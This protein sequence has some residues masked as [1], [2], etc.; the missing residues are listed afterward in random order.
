MRIMMINETLS[1]HDDICNKIALFAKPAL[2]RT[3]LIVDSAKSI[4][5]N[6]REWSY[7]LCHE[8]DIWQ[9]L[10]QHILNHYFLSHYYFSIKKIEYT[11]Q[12]TC[13]R[14]I[15]SQDSWDKIRPTFIEQNRFK[16]YVDQILAIQRIDNALARFYKHRNAQKQYEKLFSTFM[17]DNGVV[18]GNNPGE[19]QYELLHQEE[20]SMCTEW[21][22]DP[23]DFPFED[24]DYKTDKKSDAEREKYI[25]DLVRKCY[26]NPGIQFESHNQIDLH[27]QLDLHI[28]PQE[29][30]ERAARLWELSPMEEAEILLK[31]F[32]KN[33][34][35]SQHQNEA[36]DKSYLK[37]KAI[38]MITGRAVLLL[39]MDSYTRIRMKYY[40]DQES[41]VE[42]REKTKDDEIEWW[43]F[44]QFCDEYRGGIE[45]IIELSEFRVDGQLITVNALK[46][47]LKS[48]NKRIG[49]KLK[50]YEPVTIVCDILDEYHKYAESITNYVVKY[51]TPPMEQDIDDNETRPRKINVPV[52][53]DVMVIPQ[54]TKSVK[55]TQYN[56]DDDDD[57][58]DSDYDEKSEISNNQSSK[59]HVTTNDKGYN[60][61]DTDHEWMGLGGKDNLKSN[62]H[63][64]QEI[65]NIGRY[66]QECGYQENTDFFVEL[67]KPDDLIPRKIEETFAK[68]HEKCFGARNESHQRFV[69]I[70]DRRDPKSLKDNAGK[71]ANYALNNKDWSDQVYCIQM[72]QEHGGV[73]PTE[74]VRLPEALFDLSHCILPP[75][76]TNIKDRIAKPIGINDSLNGYMFV[77][78]YHVYN[79]DTIRSYFSYCGSTQRFE[80]VDVEKFWPSLF[81]QQPTKIPHKFDKTDK[82]N[83]NAMRDAE[84]DTFMYTLNDSKD[85]KDP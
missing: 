44:E 35:K 8:D 52:Q 77:L 20:E 29:T 38:D 3:I 23:Q 82:E 73:M 51:A 70:V 49:G 25:L 68:L 83:V 63:N 53:I 28:P 61:T 16:I 6:H 4:K 66:L 80:L 79:P 60:I 81:I 12:D 2:M 55:S 46:D 13:I 34:F 41:K 17:K 67:L 33:V 50:L 30:I 69:F 76:S 7:F 43:G 57:D 5:C 75:Q 27:M 26:F 85:S 64:T 54:C 37:I 10:K 14:R 48:F 32:C 47:G 62:N 42:H 72:K 19:F 40:F 39:F 36:E 58:D 24:E 45:D 84:F 1:Q 15:D 59:P 71:Y 9:N 22:D 21:V 65:G 18:Y 11:K 56:S 31:K 74:F 78:S